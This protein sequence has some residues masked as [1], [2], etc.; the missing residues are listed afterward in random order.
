[1][2]TFLAKSC[3][4]SRTNYKSGPS[5]DDE[6][7]LS[8]TLKFVL[9]LHLRISLMLF[10]EKNPLAVEYSSFAQYNVMCEIYVRHTNVM[11]SDRSTAPEN[12]MYYFFPLL[13][14]CFFFLFFFK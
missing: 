12:Q 6:I 8:V 3:Q 5:C 1:M 13:A 9:K 2:F 7:E 10:C 14:P 4:L 11:I